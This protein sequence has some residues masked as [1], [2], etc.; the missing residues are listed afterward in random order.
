MNFN[1][2]GVTAAFATFFSIWFGHVAVR[3]IEFMTVRLWIPVIAALGLGVTVEMAA[4]FSANK[5]LATAFGII[6]ITLL[7]DG[8]EFWRQQKRVMKGHAPANPD[9]RRHAEILARF[10]SATTLDWLN[11]NPT[12]NLLSQQELRKFEGGAS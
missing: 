1:W 8:L 4:M 12:G 3:K 9:N 6:G 2:I 10:P 7:W 11:R 5:H